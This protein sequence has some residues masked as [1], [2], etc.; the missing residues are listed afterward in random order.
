MLPPLPKL[1]QQGTLGEPWAAS[2]AIA[3]YRHRDMLGERRKQISRSSLWT[4]VSRDLQRTAHRTDCLHKYNR[5][6][7]SLY[8]NVHREDVD[9]CFLRSPSLSSRVRSVSHGLLA[10][11][12]PATAIGTCLGS[13]GSKYRDLLYGHLYPEISRGQ[14]IEQIVF[15]SITALTSHCMQMFIEKMSIFASSA[16]QACPAGYAR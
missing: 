2:A 7:Q 8:A 13:G 15:T 11:P 4:L 5:S 12:L 16:P 3:C 14:R 1:V 10:L 9:I 6:H